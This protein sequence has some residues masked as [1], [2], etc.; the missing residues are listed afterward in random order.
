MGKSR[1]RRR[2]E[3]RSLAMYLYFSPTSKPLQA[4]PQ[5]PEMYLSALQLRLQNSSFTSLEVCHILSSKIYSRGSPI[6]TIQHYL[7]EIPACNNHF[8]QSQV[9]QLKD[10]FVK[11]DYY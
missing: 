10:P 4:T 9:L 2:C 8:L 1:L 11:H 7:R 6:T 5:L 3:R